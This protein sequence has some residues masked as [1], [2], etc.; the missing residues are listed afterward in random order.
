MKSLDTFYLF[1]RSPGD[2]TTALL[3]NGRE[4]LVLPPPTVYGLNA[5]RFEWG[6]GGIGPG[7]T[8]EVL[9]A[10][11]LEEDEGRARE[12]AW[13]VKTRLIAKLPLKGAVV[14]ASELL[15]VVTE[16]EDERGGV[17]RIAATE[18]EAE[19]HEVS[20]LLRLLMFGTWNR[21]GRGD[22]HAP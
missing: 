6:Y 11:F 16:S 5:T 13:Q 22:H 17:K 8:T 15:W 14:T 4:S 19:T 12:L 20:R 21:R 9:L 1:W 18:T 2:C 7:V 10:D 3:R